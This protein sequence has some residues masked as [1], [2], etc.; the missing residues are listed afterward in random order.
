M[1]DDDS[2]DGGDDEGRDASRSARRRRAADEI[3]ERGADGDGDVEDGEDAVALAS[4]V[5]VGE[6]RGGED[7]EAGFADA[8]CGVADV[9]RVVGV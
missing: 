5:E 6:E 2:G 4:G 8:E 1:R 3:A 7:A 9:E